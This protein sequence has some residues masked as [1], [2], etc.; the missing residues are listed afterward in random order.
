MLD[1]PSIRLRGYDFNKI[2]GG[3]ICKSCKKWI[4]ICPNEDNYVPVLNNQ[5]EFN[6]IC[7]HLNVISEASPIEKMNL[8]LGFSSA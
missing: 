2:V 6:R 1:K 4:C 8:V 5:D 3:T 7:K